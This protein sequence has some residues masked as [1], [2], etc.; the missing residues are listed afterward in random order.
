MTFAGK[1]KTQLGQFQFMRLRL[2]RQ[3]P[4]KLVEFF[5]ALLERSLECLALAVGRR[6]E[7]LALALKGLA[8]LSQS[9]LVRLRCCGEFVAFAVQITLKF[10]YFGFPRLQRRL[11]RFAFAERG[12]HDIELPIELLLE[13]PAFGFQRVGDLAWAA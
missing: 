2:F 10:G 1:A 4:A 11:Q 9:L 7:S 12:G 13:H 5:A 6:C 3:L 8:K